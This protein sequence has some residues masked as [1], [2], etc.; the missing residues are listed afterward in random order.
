MAEDPFS[1]M[2]NTNEG[3][4]SLGGAGVEHQTSVKV[5]RDPD[6][7]GLC[8]VAPCGECGTEHKVTIP[9]DEFIFGLVG[10]TPPGWSYDRRHGGFYPGIKCVGCARPIVLVFTPDECK[11]HLN[12]GVASKQVSPQYIQA[13]SQRVQAAQRSQHGG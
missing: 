3:Y 12:A 13:G 4:G 1:D 8:F 10:A 6:K 2:K 9:W 5:E 7:Q 11:R